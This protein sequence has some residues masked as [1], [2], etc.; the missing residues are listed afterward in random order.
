MA[1]VDRAIDDSRLAIHRKEREIIRRHIRCQ[2][3]PHRLKC[4][5]AGGGIV[6]RAFAQ[7]TNATEEIYFPC[8]V[9]RGGIVSTGDV[10]AFL[11]ESAQPLTG[12]VG[13]DG[14]PVSGTSQARRSTSLLYASGSGAQILVSRERARLEFVERAVVKY[15]PPF[16][17][18]NRV[19]RSG[20]FPRTQICIAVRVG[21]WRIGPMIIRTDRNGG[22]GRHCRKEEERRKKKKRTFH[23]VSN[24][25]IAIKRGSGRVELQARMP[26]SAFSH[27]A[28]RG[29]H[30]RSG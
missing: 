13:G 5:R 25:E 16:A 9:E 1:Q 26:V 6:T 2:C 20:L 29:P 14:R 24:I 17:T 4:R 19:R 21:G 28:F 30:R 7:A 27:R 3:E 8:E 18:R 10:V 12:S 22:Y 11:V 23:S 15:F